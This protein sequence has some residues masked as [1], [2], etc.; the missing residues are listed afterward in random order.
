MIGRV[1]YC[2]RLLQTWACL[3]PLRY[4]IED[5]ILISLLSV[6]ACISFHRSL[7]KSDS[8]CLSSF[9]WSG[10]IVMPWEAWALLAN[11]VVTSMEWFNRTRT[12]GLFFEAAKAYTVS[13]GMIINFSIEFGT[14]VRQLAK[15][16]LCHLDLG[17]SIS[18]PP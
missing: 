4:R 11:T 13:N 14:A 10:L 5:Q 2:R 1:K 6:P 9:V 17:E 8:C 15:S 3:L 18:K 7:S 16:D 12:R